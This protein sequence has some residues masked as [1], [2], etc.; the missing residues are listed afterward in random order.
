MR[1]AICTRQTVQCELVSA[2]VESNFQRDRCGAVLRVDVIRLRHIDVSRDVSNGNVAYK[3]LKWKKEQIEAVAF[4][5]NPNI[6]QTSGTVL[7]KGKC[8][9]YLGMDKR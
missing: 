1:N 3:C 6:F 5:L 9:K 8:Q 2:R 4:S 7:Y